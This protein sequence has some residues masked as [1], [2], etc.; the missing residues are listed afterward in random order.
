VNQPS[1]PA[2][3]TVR[4]R[5]SR[6]AKSVV[7]RR[8]GQSEVDRYPRLAKSVFRRLKGQRDVRDRHAANA[9]PS[10][11]RLPPSA[12][13]LEHLL[14]AF[15]VKS[16]E[17]DIDINRTLP[18]VEEILEH[19]YRELEGTAARDDNEEMTA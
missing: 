19:M 2:Q 6:I 17:D 4:E 11:R 14:N 1:V 12:P 5:V 10:G 8:E 16:G 13:F 7:R 9:V 3:A 18:Q 15:G